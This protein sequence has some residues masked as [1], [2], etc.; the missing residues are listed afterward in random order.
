MTKTARYCWQIIGAGLALT[1]LALAGDYLVIQIKTGDSG[2]DSTSLGS[3]QGGIDALAGPND[4]YTIV[5][6]DDVNAAC[7]YA[8]DHVYDYESTVVVA[9]GRDDG[10]NGYSD[11]VQTVN[12]PQDPYVMFQDDSITSANFCGRNGSDVSFND[13]DHWVYDDTAGSGSPLDSLPMED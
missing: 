8:E 3:L 5:Q 12:G 4:H 1:T 6:V 7:Q 11:T 10:Q 2:L 9:H 13:M